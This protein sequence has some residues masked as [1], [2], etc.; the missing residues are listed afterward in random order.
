M[1]NMIA[2]QRLMAKREDYRTAH[3]LHL[4]LCIPTAGLW[5]FIWMICALSNSIERGKIDRKLA[6]LGGE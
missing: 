5:V 6:R 1:D 4:L 3:I 2:A